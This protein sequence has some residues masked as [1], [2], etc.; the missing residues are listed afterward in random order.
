V[1]TYNHD[2]DE[3]RRGIL[4]G[5]IPSAAA[6]SGATSSIGTKRD[7][8]HFI[9]TGRKS[10]KT[11]RMPNGALESVLDIG[12]L[13]TAVRSPARDIHITSG[14]D[15]TSL[16]STVKFAEAEHVTIFD[17]DEVN[18]YDQRNTIIT[19]SRSAILRGWRE[20]GTNDLWRIPLVPV[21][22]NNNTD[23]LLVK[24]PPSEYLPN[25]PLPSEA[26]HNVYEL[27]TQPE[28]VR[29]LHAAAGF[30]TKPTWYKAVKNGQFV[31]WPGLTAAAVARHF[32]ESEE[33]IKGTH[34]RRAAAYVQRRIS[35]S[36][37]ALSTTRQRS[38]HTHYQA[39]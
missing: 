2:D 28:L 15:E 29:Y 27:K 33:T 23:T 5:S 9:S 20:P 35:R 32:P 17:R 11:F 1:Q 13:A 14:V 3:L 24:R 16:I 6:D 10:D 12:H 31:S 21:V 8:R 39:S 7:S 19:V 30:P 38:Q 26:T 37:R 25:R 4:N 36:A 18:I 22:R 34:A